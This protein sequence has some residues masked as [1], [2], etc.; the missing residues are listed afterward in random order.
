MPAVFTSTSLRCLV[1]MRLC[2]PSQVRFGHEFSPPLANVGAM[3]ASRVLRLLDA[4]AVSGM[5]T[6]L[7]V[8]PRCDHDFVVDPS[9]QQQQHGVARVSPHGL[10]PFI[11]AGALVQQPF[12]LLDHAAKVSLAEQQAKA[13]SEAHAQ[14]H[15]A[16][17]G[18][19]S[20]STV[21]RVTG[22]A[23]SK[24]SGAGGTDGGGAPSLMSRL[25]MAAA[26]SRTPKK[27]Q[28]QP[29]SAGVSSVAA[30]EGADV[31]SVASV[32]SSTS[33]MSE[34][35]A[36][37]SVAEAWH[38]MRWSHEVKHRIHSMVIASV[39]WGV[40]GSL[41]QSDRDTFDAFCQVRLFAVCLMC[42]CLCCGGHVG[43]VF[44]LCSCCLSLS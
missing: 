17:G 39:V 41:Q 32:P 21:H 7:H 38:R 19:A 16:S 27:A 18:D 33:G 31:G 28:Q 29:G 1:C 34:T 11:S 2:A 35:V 24:G 42:A 26:R 15:A 3:V 40:G 25:R 12:K 4:L 13:A 30:N 14:E 20:G 10:S 44:A 9:Q 8:A 37:T 23:E 6:R 36:P 43:L 22:T 5:T